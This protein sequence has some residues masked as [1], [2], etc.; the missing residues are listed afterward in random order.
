MG[1][2]NAELNFLLIPGVRALL[3]PSDQFATCILW[4]INSKWVKY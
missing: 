4:V 3:I 1:I 2:Q